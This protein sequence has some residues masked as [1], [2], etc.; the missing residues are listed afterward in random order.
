MESPGGHL[1]CGE[2]V[3]VENSC[4]AFLAARAEP[5]RAKVEHKKEEE[6]ELPMLRRRRQVE[7]VEEEE[8]EDEGDFISC[9]P[10]TLYHQPMG[11]CDWR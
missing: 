10:G 8:E 11:V 5:R 9:P 6:E 3:F 4:L 1:H 2:G 7:E